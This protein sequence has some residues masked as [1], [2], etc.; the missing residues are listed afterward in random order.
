MLFRRLAVVKNVF[1]ST[2]SARRATCL[3]GSGCLPQCHFYPRSPRGERHSGRN[4][5]KD[6]AISIHA[7]R[8][9][10]DPVARV[11]RPATKTFLSTLSARRATICF[12]R[13][14]PKCK[15]LSTLSARRA[16]GGTMDDFFGVLFLS[17]LSARRATAAQIKDL[18]W[19]LFL[20]TLSARRA[21]FMVFRQRFRF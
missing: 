14:V 1:L 15:F 7:L 21:T 4:S 13:T 19:S 2:L 18:S 9:E 17:T 12:W 10:S 16:T 3:K 5:A 11:G 6:C 8:E 20:S